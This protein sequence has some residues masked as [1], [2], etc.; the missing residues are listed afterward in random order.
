MEA[1]PIG[2]GP[3]ALV[4]SVEAWMGTCR[5][6]VVGRDRVGDLFTPG[7]PGIVALWHFSLVYILYHFRKVRGLIMVSGSR[8]GDWVARAVRAWGQVPVRGSRHK[9]GLAA[10]RGMAEAMRRH[11][12]GAGIVADGS[13]GPARVAQK[14]AVVLAR[15]TGVPMVPVG[16][17]ARPAWRFNSWD[18]LVLPV[19]GARVV[20]AYGAPIHVPA[21]A[22]GGTIEAYRN[23]LETDLN[24]ATAE[25]E[26][27]L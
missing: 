13:R 22:R 2:W 10:I 12:Y 14:G 25:A 9:G 19:P 7:R 17:A 21:G 5:L 8:D 27:A 16:F 20:V 23:R 6:R 24:G 3:K 4:R 11:R 1:G 26:A 15:D 18:R